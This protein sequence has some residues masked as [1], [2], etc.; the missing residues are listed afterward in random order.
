MRDSAGVRIIENK[1]PKWSHAD[2]WIVDSLPS[3]DVGRESVEHAELLFR[4][5][6]V[7]ALSDGLAILNGGSSQILLFDS[8]GRFRQAVG[9]AGGGPDEF[10]RLTGLYVCAGDTLVVNDFSR[11]IRFSAAGQFVGTDNITST[12]TRSRRAASVAG[13]CGHL[14]MRETAAER[15]PPGTAGPLLNTFFWT[16]YHGEVRDTIGS[17]PSTVVMMKEIEGQFQ[18]LEVPWGAKGVWAIWGNRFYVG[19]SNEAQILVYERA[20]G[21]IQIIRWSAA[22]R[23]ISAA[24][25]QT[26]QAKRE[27]LM[28]AFP[29]ASRVI[30]PLAEYFDL[31]EMLPLFLTLRTDDQGNLWVRHYPAFVAGRPDLF[32]FD[33]PRRYNPSPGNAPEVWSVF[34]ASG[35]WL[36]EVRT[37]ADLSVK[38][39][40][41]NRLIGVWKDADD[42]EHVRLYRVRKGSLAQDRMRDHNTI[43]PHALMA[44]PKRAGS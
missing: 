39:I 21:L 12:R 35:R 15:P 41:D 4:V 43:T 26:Y 2:S 38:S 7:S 19:S 17:F 30:P 25:R 34:D 1:A 5:Q 8:V 20:K 42:M 37:P 14:V 44:P 24:D 36:G 28:K 22:S 32:D 11:I 9:R 6:D 3:L 29:P 18:P 31:P 23:E 16:D 40:R 27:W 33:I 10:S 13:D